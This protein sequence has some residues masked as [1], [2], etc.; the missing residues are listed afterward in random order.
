MTTPADLDV[1]LAGYAPT[2][3]GRAHLA[4]AV[5]LLAL[6]ARSSVRLYLGASGLLAETMQRLRAGVR[7]HA[8]LAA[9]GGVVHEINNDPSFRATKLLS[10]T[11]QA[12]LDALVRLAG[13]VLRLD[14][15][16]DVAAREMLFGCVR[17]LGAAAWHDA[18]DRRA[19]AD[20]ARAQE[21]AAVLGMLRD[22][23]PDARRV[24]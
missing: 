7:T 8:D 24:A 13:V 19:C 17:M 12:A 11:E 3:E 14:V 22:A 15:G 20:E 18:C 4:G 21:E 10:R 2:P 23:A 6:H 1:V 5:T 9:V 16:D